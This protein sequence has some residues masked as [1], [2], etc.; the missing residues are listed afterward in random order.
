MRL[1]QIKIDFSAEHDRLLMLVA[2]SDGGVIRLWLTRRYVKLL[3]PLLMKM[4]EETSPRIKTQADP[5]AKKALMGFEHEQAVKQADFATPFQEEG[6][7]GPLGDEPILLA[8]IQTGRDAADL[9]VLSLHPGTGQG[10]NLTL[11]A[12]LL[13]AICK[14]IVSA[15]NKAEWGL[16]MKLPGIEPGGESEAAPRVLN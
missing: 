14:L 6:R 8:R 7:P 2:T 4:V 13:H 9:P 10:L 1:H 11:N 16:D 5:E 12:T 15:V 3:W